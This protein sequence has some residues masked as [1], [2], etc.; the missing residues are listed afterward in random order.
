[1]NCK[2]SDGSVSTFKIPDV[3]YVPKLNRP[4]FSWQLVRSKGFM[5]IDDGKGMHIVKD[6]KTWLEAKFDG[7]LHHIPEATNFVF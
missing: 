6:N 7:K 5:L 1:M 4:L 2:L 3:L